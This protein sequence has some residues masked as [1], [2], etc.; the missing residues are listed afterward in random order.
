MNT[1]NQVCGDDSR[2]RQ[3]SAGAGGQPQETLEGQPSGHCNTSR[4]SQQE[5]R[6]LEEIILDRA[7][8]RKG[9]A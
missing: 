9:G 1:V 2:R 5:T 4:A 7:Q 6:P 3:G 8:A